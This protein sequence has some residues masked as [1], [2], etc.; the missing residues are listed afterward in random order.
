MS[1]RPKSRKLR[2]LEEAAD[3]VNAVLAEIDDLPEYERHEILQSAA[4]LQVLAEEQMAG[5]D[6]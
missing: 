3:A 1:R 6:W 4:H 5:D 2:L